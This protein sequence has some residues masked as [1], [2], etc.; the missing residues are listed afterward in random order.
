[1]FKEAEKVEN[2]LCMVSEEG[3]YCEASVYLSVGGT[4]KEGVIE[5]LTEV[6]K[7]ILGHDFTLTGVPTDHEVHMQWLRDFGVIVKENE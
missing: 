2:F 7:T 1:M 3:G 6:F 5:K 4:S